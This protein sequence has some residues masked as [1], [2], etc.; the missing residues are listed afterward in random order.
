MSA[1]SLELTQAGSGTSAIHAESGDTIT[2][3][4]ASTVGNSVL[5]NAMVNLAGLSEITGVTFVASTAGN[6]S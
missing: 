5:A 1:V 4:L 3:V 2:I 6:A